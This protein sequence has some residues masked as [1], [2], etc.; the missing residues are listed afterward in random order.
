MPSEIVNAL[1]S[2]D[3]APYDHAAQNTLAALGGASGEMIF[4]HPEPGLCG[5]A[6][7]A[8]SIKD[9]ATDRELLSDEVGGLHKTTETTAGHSNLLVVGK[10][11]LT[12]YRFDGHYY[13]PA[14]C[15]TRSNGPGSRANPGECP[16]HQEA[17]SEAEATSPTAKLV[18]G[19]GSQ[20]RG[21][22]GDV[23]QVG[24]GVSAPTVLYK[25]DAAYTQEA[26]EAKYSGSVRLL[27]V[28]DKEGRAQ[29]INV[30]RS[31]GM[32]LDEK[33]IEAVQKWKFNPGQRDGEP[34]A[35]RAL[36]EVNF[37]LL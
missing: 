13:H 11:T 23:Y 2:P 32:G 18:N 35:V 31:L 36:I 24:G 12:L 6:G 15:F 22:I 26:R 28:V 5:S 27:V 7:C 33:A 29:D 37:R 19:A 4:A 21:G 30:V 16:S 17:G 14:Q 8:W 3:I 9:V 20:D 10:E 34:V 25:V 1:D